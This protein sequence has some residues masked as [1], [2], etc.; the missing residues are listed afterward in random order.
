MEY[1]INYDKLSCTELHAARILRII[2]DNIIS[3]EKEADKIM[4]EIRTGQMQY[5]KGMRSGI[6][7]ITDIRRYITIARKIIDKYFTK[8]D[9]R[10]RIF[11]LA[12]HLYGLSMLVD[13]FK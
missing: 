3:R 4:D 1:R 12:Q 10:D 7:I 2:N 6:A 5:C 11:Y 9:D 13:F 8:N